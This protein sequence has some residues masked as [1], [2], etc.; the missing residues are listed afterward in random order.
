MN[1]AVQPENIISR[2]A[3]AGKVSPRLGHRPVT[4][5]R[6]LDRTLKEAL[7]RRQLATALPQVLAMN[8]ISRQSTRG[9]I[10]C[11]NSY[12]TSATTRSLY[13]GQ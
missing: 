9:T 3:L 5:R 11:F 2:Q 12:F 10:T 8:G 4:C 13:R 1:I 7:Q 6:W